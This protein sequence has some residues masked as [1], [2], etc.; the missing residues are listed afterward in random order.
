M[1]RLA[2][3]HLEIGVDVA[4]HLV[5]RISVDKGFVVSLFLFCAFDD[6]GFQPVFSPFMSIM[7]FC[8]G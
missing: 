7:L 5:L 6:F 2:L 4:G 3:L 1:R 8:T